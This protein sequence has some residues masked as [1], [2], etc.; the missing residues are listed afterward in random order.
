M[1]RAYGTFA[2]GGYRIDGKA[3]GDE[4]RAITSIDAVD[5]KVAYANAPVKK[6]VLTPAED[7]LLTQLLEG[8]VTSGTGKAAALPGYTV[9]GKTGTTENY[10]D[11][12]FVGYTPQLVTA[13]WVGYPANLRPMLTEFHGGPV[14]GGTFPA[15]IWKSFMESALKQIGAQPRGFPTPPY[16]SVT[17]HRVTY[18]DGQVELDNGDCRDTSNVVYFSGHGPAH[19]ANCKLN[20]VDVPNVVGLGVQRARVRLTAQPLTP[21]LI[22]KPA[23]PGERVGVVLKQFPRSGTLGSY[24]RVTLVLAKPLHGTVPRVVGLELQQAK[25]LLEQRKLHVT[26]AAG[27]GKPGRVLAQKPLGG[28]AAR[29]GMAVQITVGRAG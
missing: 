13:V 2:N 21:Q 18:R 9:A 20:E 4:P 11:A 22:Y 7:E 5:G 6:E 1:A 19:T 12:W 29:P 15:L 28:V 10:G 17:S 16:L 26:V 25:T 24:G 14:T 8:V 3:F 27:K 23:S